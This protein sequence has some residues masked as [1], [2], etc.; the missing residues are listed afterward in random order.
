MYRKGFKT[1]WLKRDH[2]GDTFSHMLALTHF[3]VDNNTSTNHRPP[4][5]PSILPVIHTN[6]K[7]RNGTS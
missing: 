5:E 7:S 4:I 3:S 1:V 2:P 6:V